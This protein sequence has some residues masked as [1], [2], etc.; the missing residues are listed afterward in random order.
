MLARMDGRDDAEAVLIAG[1][2][3]TGKTSVLEEIAEICEERAIRYGAIDLDWLAWFDAGGG[4]HDAGV[5]VMLRNVEAVVAN[6]HEAG[7]RR[8][9]LAG[10][11]EPTD[12]GALRSTLAM[13]LAVVRLTLPLDEIERRLSVSVTTGRQADIEIARHWIAEKRD[14][15][16]GDVTIE[17]DR[18]VRDVALEIVTWLG[19]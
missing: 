8:F 10:A 11:M 18:P 7:V 19:W 3:G 17:N 5:P 16:V 12:E 14:E 15:G 13:P 1:P 2:Y 9:A 4:D 6:Y